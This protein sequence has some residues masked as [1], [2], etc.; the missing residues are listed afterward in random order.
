M[1]FGHRVCELGCV[2][3]YLLANSPVIPVP[4]LPRFWLHVAHGAPHAQ[5][6]V[7]DDDQARGP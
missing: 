5:M 2:V 6:P 1:K 4:L 7:A 3:P